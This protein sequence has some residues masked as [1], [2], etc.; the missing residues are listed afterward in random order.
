VCLGAL[1]LTC[2]CNIANQELV[3]D[4]SVLH[5]EITSSGTRYSYCKPVVLATLGGCHLLEGLV[6]VSVEACKEDCAVLQRK[7]CEGYCAH[8]VGAA[9]S[10][11]S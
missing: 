3:S 7:D 6:V 8:P 1:Q 5:Y 10:N 9:K 2:A 11:S 4:S